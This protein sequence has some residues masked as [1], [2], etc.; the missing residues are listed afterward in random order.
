MLEQHREDT[1]SFRCVCGGGLVGCILLYACESSFPTYCHTVLPVCCYSVLCIAFLQLFLFL[2]LPSLCCDAPMVSTHLLCA[3]SVSFVFTFC[4]CPCS[5]S[6]AVLHPVCCMICVDAHFCSCK[7][8]S[9]VHGV[10]CAFCTSL[11][12]FRH[13][14][15]P[16]VPSAPPCLC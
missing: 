16:F 15:H 4:F 12:R 1:G 6:A 3:L 10:F 9:C 8:I 7:V 14:D 13:T 2:F 11:P 5:Q